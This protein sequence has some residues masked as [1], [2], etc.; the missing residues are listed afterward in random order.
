MRAG[1]A[2]S[3]VAIDGGSSSGT[4]DKIIS[5]TVYLIPFEVTEVR[6]L[7]AKGIK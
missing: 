1:E 3:I 7:A 5:G 2:W 4:A 6:K